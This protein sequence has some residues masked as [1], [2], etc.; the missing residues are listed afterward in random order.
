MVR[1]ACGVYAHVG[2]TVSCRAFRKHIEEI[3]EKLQY[4]DQLVVQGEAFH[5]W[6]IEAPESVAQEFPAAECGLNVRFVP[7]EEPYHR[8]KVTLLKRPHTLLS[9]WPIFPA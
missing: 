9:P 7:D 3:Q 5:L 4:K 6:V 2:G 1:R 8:R